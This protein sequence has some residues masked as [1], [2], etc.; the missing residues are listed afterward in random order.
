M[1]RRYTYKAVGDVGGFC[2]ENGK[3]VTDWLEYILGKQAEPPSFMRRDAPPE[4]KRKRK[5]DAEKKAKE[6][7]AAAEALHV[8]C[9]A[10]AGSL[11]S[12]P[13]FALRCPGCNTC[14]G[15][16]WCIAAGALACV[17]QITAKP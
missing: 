13:K 10:H 5:G 4:R 17:P 12:S 6:A 1:C 15:C 14:I 7:A 8:S 11:F 2:F 16:I 9:D 3:A